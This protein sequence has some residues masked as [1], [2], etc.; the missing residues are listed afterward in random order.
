MVVKNATPER[1][2]ERAKLIA[3][4]QAIAAEL[5]RVPGFYKFHQKSTCPKYCWRK[6]WARWS[7]A[8]IEAGLVPNSRT[9]RHND[10]QM[11]EKFA[12]CART[13]GRIPSFGDLHVWRENGHPIPRYTTYIAHFGSKREMVRR[14]RQWALE[15]PDRADIAA[16]IPDFDVTPAP[17]PAGWVYLLRLRSRFKIGCSRVVDRRWHQIRN[18]LPEGANLIHVIDT[19][20][21]L[22]VEAYWHRRFGLQRTHGEWFKLTPSDIS[23]FKRWKTM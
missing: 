6:Y 18:L 5:G 16:M 10:E 14:L 9:P 12:E 11:L 20:D 7:D 21:P 22:G 23:A 13:L 8:V 1:M 3:E 2:A 19:D 4:L 17:A 15:S